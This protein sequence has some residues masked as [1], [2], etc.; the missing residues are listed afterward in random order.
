MKALR[1]SLILFAL[2]LVLTGL[3]Y[4]LVTLGLGQAL[5]PLQ[6]N[7]SLVISDG[8]VI[9]SSLIAQNFGSDKY[10]HPR[11]SAAGQGYDAANSGGSNLAPTSPDL[12]KAV[13][14]RITAMKALDNSAIVPADLV[15]A[16]A[17]GLDPDISMASAQFQAVRVAQARNESVTRIEAL[18]AAL[19]EDRTFGVLGEPRVNV[20]ELNRAL[21][22]EAPQR[23]PEEP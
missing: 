15:T 17:S 16:S 8:K 20:F 7:G 1:A 13:E 10:F 12:V 2:M 5:F 4:P 18:V 14:D 21:D 6:A 9:G 23:A 3:I 11:P 22:N 19:A